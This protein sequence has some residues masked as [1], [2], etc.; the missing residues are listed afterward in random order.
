MA[1]TTT[2]TIPNGQT[3]SDPIAVH[4]SLIG[5]VMPAAFTGTAISFQGSADG[6]TYQPVYNDSGSLASVVVA[7][8][9]AIGLD[10]FALA[11]APWAYIKLV[12]NAAEAAVRAIQLSY[13]S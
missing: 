5:I 7:A 2:C 13:K 1:T 8:S 9:R 11:L 4:S 10:A 6:V 12:S 3:V